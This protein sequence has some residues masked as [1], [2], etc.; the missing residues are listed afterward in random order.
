M[1]NNETYT[2]SPS[3]VCL[4]DSDKPKGLTNE[5]QVKP[6]E[7]GMDANVPNEIDITSSESVQACGEIQCQQASLS[8]STFTSMRI[9]LIAR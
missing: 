4:S 7:Q 8:P 2:C 1:A 9:R 3:E 5:G 6:V